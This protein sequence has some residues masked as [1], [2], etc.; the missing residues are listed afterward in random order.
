[1][2]DVTFIVS[3]GIGAD[4]VIE[5]G[6][7]IAQDS[8]SA[9]FVGFPRQGKAPLNVVFEP[10]LDGIASEYRWDFGDGDTASMRNPIHTYNNQGIYD[11][12][13]WVR[14][15][16][17]DCSHIDSLVKSE[18]I[19][20]SELEADFSAAPTAGEA[21]LMVQFTD[22]SGGTPQFWNWDFGDG[23]SSTSQ[24]PLHRYDTAGFYDVFLRVQDG[25]FADSLLRLD[26][27]NV[28]TPYTDLA[29]DIN[30]VGAKP[31]FDFWIYYSWTNIGTVTAENCTLKVLP[32]EE[33]VFADVVACDTITTGTY[34]G[35]VWAGDTIL[36]PLGVIAPSSWPGGCV[37]VV[38]N[39]P[40]FVPIGDS[41]ETEAWLVTETPDNNE[42]DNY[43]YHI[44]EVTGS[45]DPNDKKCS[46]RGSGDEYYIEADQRLN[47]MV[48]FENKAEATAE[49][50][51]IRV[52]DT[53]SPLFDWKTLSLG[54]MSHPED[55]DCDFDPYTG[56]I[57]WFC[58][59]I[60]LPPNV[61]P[62][63][64]EGYFLYSIAP[65]SGLEPGTRLYN[66][67]WIRFDFNA[68]LMAPEEGPLYRTIA[69]K[70][71]CGDANG[72]ESINILD[73][74]FLIAYV[75]QEGPLPDPLESADVNSDGTVNILDITYLIA[76][77]YLDGPEPTCP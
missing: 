6:Y 12:K 64:G 40:E 45:I 77:I 65:D 14:L 31:G 43:F 28:D 76:Y 27:I 10:V 71:I 26:Y 68:W 44:F 63:E 11:V 50:V 46:P 7:I 49:A 69:A 52:V 16:L 15:E 70:Y 8:V 72:D 58:D 57:T 61:N 74:T 19:I 59:S 3:D 48:Q 62:P 47:F 37:K 67:A 20:V 54:E 25:E 39:L 22:L 2:Y 29:V 1:M 60:M 38:G 41:L 32:P 33:M 73:I 36:I 23:N 56:I 4:T 55:C 30:D 9:D 21:P 75:Y 42:A 53:L 24:N 35:Y 51:Y 18:Y 17:G 66:T 34:S 5:P 13:L